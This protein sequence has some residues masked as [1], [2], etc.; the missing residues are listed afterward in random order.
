MCVFPTL[1]HPGAF[2]RLKPPSNVTLI[3]KVIDASKT[4]KAVEKISVSTNIKDVLIGA[5]DLPQD[6]REYIKDILKEI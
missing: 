3:P 6:S 2:N 4:T 5:L 1:H